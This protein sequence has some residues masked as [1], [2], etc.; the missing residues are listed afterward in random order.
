MSL[1]HLN[2]ASDTR[3]KQD[4]W[5]DK[6]DTLQIWLHLNCAF[7]LSLSV[8]GILKLKK[9]VVPVN[10]LHETSEAISHPDVVSWLRD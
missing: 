7:A 6:V 3:L 1:I 5:R 10:A 9:S 2:K 8:T 4:V